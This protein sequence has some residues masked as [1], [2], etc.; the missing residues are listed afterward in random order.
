MSENRKGG[1]D[2]FEGLDWDNELDAWDKAVEQPGGA[3]VPESFSQPPPPVAPAVPSAAPPST[4]RG[5]EDL[6]ASQHGGAKSRPLYRPPS[7]TPSA[8]STRT[9][10]RTPPE[11]PLPS[12]LDDDDEMASTRGGREA[13]VRRST[14][15]DDDDENR[16]VVAEVPQDLLDQLEAAGIRRAQKPAPAAG[17]KPK[18]AP[19]PPPPPP[20]L[21]D[22]EQPDEQ[23]SEHPGPEA[24][25][26]S[27]VTSAPEVVRSLRARP[28]EVEAKSHPPEAPVQRDGRFDPFHGLDLEPPVSE[29]VGRK[30]NEGPQL[31]APTERKHSPEDETAIFDKR[32]LMAAGAAQPRRDADSTLE[33]ADPFGGVQDP[34]ATPDPFGAGEEAP[35]L[36]EGEAPREDDQ[37]LIDLLRGEDQS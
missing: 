17:S 30:A 20:V 29:T 28:Q 4:S 26:P 7:A 21:H 34:F 10:A 14:G 24:E 31:L 16:T 32:A 33:T 2:P 12:L 1:S 25:D 18:A 5:Q 6:R 35:E 3:S 15:D 37:E 19:V 27:V 36:A 8:P 23:T 11:R 22:Y 13:P 9:G